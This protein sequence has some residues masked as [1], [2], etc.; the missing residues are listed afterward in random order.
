MRACKT[1]QEIKRIERLFRE[2]M[3]CHANAALAE[4]ADRVQAR[5]L[6]LC[7]S[8]ALVE[9]L[10]HLI[11]LVLKLGAFQFGPVSLDDQ[12]RTGAA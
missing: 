5:K 10:L 7:H 12:L 8:P 11:H 4:V 1:K 2:H 9:L 6:L 3:E